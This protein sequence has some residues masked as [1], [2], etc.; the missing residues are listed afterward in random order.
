MQ[1]CITVLY[2]CFKHARYQ[3]EVLYRTKYRVR[4][5]L[6]SQELE[7]PGPGSEAASRE[8]VILRA[9]RHLPVI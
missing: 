5:I 8:H 3:I 6:Y 9:V 7:N 2:I 4:R 1:N